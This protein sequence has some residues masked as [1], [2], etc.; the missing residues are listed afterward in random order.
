LL[1]TRWLPI[2][3]ALPLALLPKDTVKA[4]R[5]IFYFLPDF[6]F[7]GGPHVE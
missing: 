4:E 6:F 3:I 2:D 1:P 5:C 7:S